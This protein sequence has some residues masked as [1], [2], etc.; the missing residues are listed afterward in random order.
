MSTVGRRTGG[1]EKQEAK[2]KEEAGE[3]K[4]FFWGGDV[5]VCK[6]EQRFGLYMILSIYYIIVCRQFH[7]IGTHSYMHYEL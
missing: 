3:E 6:G 5:D 4:L 1:F 7:C 2:I